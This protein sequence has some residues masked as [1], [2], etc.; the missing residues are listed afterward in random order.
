MKIEK[1]SEHIKLYQKCDITEILER[2]GMTDCNPVRTPIEA[3]TPLQKAPDD[4]QLC[5]QKLYQS[6]IGLLL[7]AATATRPDIVHATH[8][9]GQFLALPTE[10]HLVAAKRV[11][12]YLKGTP[13]MGIRYNYD[14]N[15]IPFWVYSDSSVASNL[16]A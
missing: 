1:T 14:S 12:W 4:D 11:L 2:F 15:N 8:F 6:V 10:T 3:H 5:N 16:T 13:T 7:Y 9:L